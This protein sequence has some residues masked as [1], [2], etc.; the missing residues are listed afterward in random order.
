M[1]VFAAAGRLDELGILSRLAEEGGSLAWARLMIEQETR[2]T[3][4]VLSGQR[5]GRRSELIAHWET[6]G[7]QSPVAPALTALGKAL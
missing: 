4:S 2:A 3:L 5:A 1:E 6:L 7:G